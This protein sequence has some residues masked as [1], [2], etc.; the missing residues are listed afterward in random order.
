MDCAIVLRLSVLSQSQARPA[1]SKKFF[2]F[3]FHHEAPDP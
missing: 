2:F 3:E 1:A